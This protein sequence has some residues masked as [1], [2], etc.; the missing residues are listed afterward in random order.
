MGQ[1]AQGSE[2]LSSETIRLTAHA[3]AHPKGIQW[4]S[5][6]RRAFPLRDA[7]ARGAPH[8]S[9]PRHGG[10]FQGWHPG[11]S[12]PE[13]R[14]LDTARAPRS[15]PPD[16][17]P[18]GSQ[19]P[20]RNRVYEDIEDIRVRCTDGDAGGRA[21]GSQEAAGVRG[22]LGHRARDV[23]QGGAGHGAQRG[24]RRGGDALPWA[25]GPGAA[26]RLLPL[27]HPRLPPPGLHGGAVPQPR[28]GGTSM[29]RCAS[30][31]ARG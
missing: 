13:C 21:A 11:C 14:R 30:W 29:R 19:S 26:L 2:R 31:G 8:A 23:L 22:A 20:T 25:A 28:G 6:E 24:R 16:H 10:A 9:A 3:R 1:R 12:C 18:E 4:D 15:G 5:R 7:T 27:L 17:E